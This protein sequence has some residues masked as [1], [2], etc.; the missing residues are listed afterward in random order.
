MANPYQAKVQQK[1]VHCRLLLDLLDEQGIERQLREALLQ[2]ATLHLA[3]AARL[4]LRELATY[5]QYPN[6]ESIA[7]SQQLKNIPLGAGVASELESERW[8]GELFSVEQCL[9]DP[10]MRVKRATR[11]VIASDSAPAGADII[12]S[13]TRIKEW[14]RALN[15]LAERQRAMFEEN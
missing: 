1:L 4:Y 15:R 12:E 2:G 5:L 9:L 3:I 8:L 14:W 6:A 10:D 11:G 13:P 7:D